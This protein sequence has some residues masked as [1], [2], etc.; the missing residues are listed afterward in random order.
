MISLLLLLSCSDPPPNQVEAKTIELV[1]KEVVSVNIEPE[2]NIAT[3][4][5]QVRQARSDLECISK[6]LKYQD[7]CPENE[8]IDYNEYE[9]KKCLRKK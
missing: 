8:Q 4:Q 1:E 7:T 9:E 2:Q 5:Q 6:Y 3:Q